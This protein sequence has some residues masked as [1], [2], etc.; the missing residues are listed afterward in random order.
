MGYREPDE[1]VRF[2]L[3]EQRA[4]ARLEEA[5][6]QNQMDAGVAEHKSLIQKL[7]DEWKKAVEALENAR[8]S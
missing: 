1:F 8:K 5:R 3:E 4:R 6:E 2:E 7:E